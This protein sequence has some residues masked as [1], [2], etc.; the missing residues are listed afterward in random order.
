MKKNDQMESSRI[1]LSFVEAM[2]IL[3]RDPSVRTLNAS[4]KK[5]SNTVAGIVILNDSRSG[6]IFDS[7]DDRLKNQ[8]NFVIREEWIDKYVS[9]YETVQEPPD[10]VFEEPPAIV[11]KPETK[12]LVDDNTDSSKV[13]NQ[14]QI[15]KSSPKS[16]AKHVSSESENISITK[17]VNE[18]SS[19]PKWFENCPINQ[20]GMKRINNLYFKRDCCFTKKFNVDDTFVLL[21]G[22][23]NTE[24]KFKVTN[25][26]TVNKY[27]GTRDFP[28]N[29]KD[30]I[31][32][33]YYQ[34]TLSTNEVLEL[35]ELN[36]L[37][38]EEIS[39]EFRSHIN[40]ILTS[41]VDNKNAITPGGPTSNPKKKKVTFSTPVQKLPDGYKSLE[42]G[43]VN[44]D[45]FFHSV[46]YC[47][48]GEIASGFLLKRLLERFVVCNEKLQTNSDPE[49]RLG[50]K[51]RE[52]ISTDKNNGFFEISYNIQESFERM[53]ENN[54]EYATEQDI[55][56]TIQAIRLGLLGSRC[57]NISFLIWDEKLGNYVLT[58][59][60]STEVIRI[61]KQ[62]GHFQA[63]V[64]ESG[65]KPICRELCDNI[66]FRLS[67][68][69]GNQ[70]INSRKLSGKS[71]PCDKGK[72]CSVR[73]TDQISGAQNWSNAWVSQ[74]RSDRTFDVHWCCDGTVDTYTFTNDKDP[75]IKPPKGNPIRHPEWKPTKSY[76]NY[77]NPIRHPESNTGASVFPSSSASQNATDDYSWL[78]QGGSS[79]YA[80]HLP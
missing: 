34:V 15:F 53:K 58:D 4:Y 22:D 31:N 16:V 80:N 23:T 67:K 55:M 46:M 77:R 40:G 36:M 3:T 50:D 74:I 42:C 37:D 44:N 57:E 11:L 21:I 56:L 66:K 38:L 32:I 72:F 19:R 33:H 35:C 79:A 17:P 52:F 14:Q 61:N 70:K 47:L 78:A 8:L 68:R 39:T 45:C 1:K 64:P 49:A 30:K 20:R 24:F 59:E 54:T 28:I 26:G 29:R 25:V 13:S 63:L 10:I 43:K 69:D 71:S 48:T 51:L 75:V 73:W 41:I 2:A 76:L 9:I 65:F 5:G 7:N 18:K 27:L 6:L 62:P 12:V 60:I